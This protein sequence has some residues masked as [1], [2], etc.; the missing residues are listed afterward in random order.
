VSFAK[1][2][3]GEI[4]HAGK[5]KKKPSKSNKGLLG[6]FLIFKSPYLEKKKLKVARFRQCVLVGHHN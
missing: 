4:S 5:K 2:K 3:F 6:I 1:T